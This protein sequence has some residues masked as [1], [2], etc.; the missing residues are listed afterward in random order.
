[1]LFGVCSLGPIIPATLRLPV[2]IFLW[3]GI[4]ASEMMKIARCHLFFFNIFKFN[5]ETASTKSSLLVFYLAGWFFGLVLYGVFLPALVFENLPP[6]QLFLSLDEEVKE[7]Q[8]LRHGNICQLLH[9][10]SCPACSGQLW[11]GGV[12][13]ALGREAGASQLTILSLMLFFRN[14]N[15][16]FNFS[17]LPADNIRVAMTEPSFQ[18]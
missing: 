15:K 3:D 7:S 8:S 18:D 2:E 11:V 13:M 10:H 9:Q 6:P 16:C 4:Y 1:M 12:H 17:F 14:S 5:L